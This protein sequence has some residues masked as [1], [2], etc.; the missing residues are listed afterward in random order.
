MRRMTTI[1]AT[2]AGCL[3]MKL[4]VYAPPGRHQL[5]PAVL[6]LDPTPP[7]S[8]VPPMQLGRGHQR[9]N[10]VALDAE[11]PVRRRITVD[12]THVLRALH[13]CQ[14]ARRVAELRRCY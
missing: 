5:V 6:G 13:R 12:A 3:A 7:L 1:A 11:R 8:A 2:P 9:K 4:A 10:L 14:L